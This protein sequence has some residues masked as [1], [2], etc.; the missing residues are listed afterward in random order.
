MADL[1][2]VIGSRSQVRLTLEYERRRLKEI[3]WELLVKNAPGSR[4]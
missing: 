2:R 4:R 3:L 1:R